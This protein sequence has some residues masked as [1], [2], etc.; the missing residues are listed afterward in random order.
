LLIAPNTEK[1]EEIDDKINAIIAAGLAQEVPVLYCLSKRLLG[2]ALQMTI[3]QSIVAILDP[4][5]AY[6]LFKTIVQYSQTHKG[7]SAV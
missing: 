5:G 4:N 1:S 3:K 6:D 2:K 7:G